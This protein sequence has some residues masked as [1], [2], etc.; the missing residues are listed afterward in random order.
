MELDVLTGARQLIAKHQPILQVEWL[1]SPKPQLRQTLEGFG[2]RVFEAGQN[3]LAIHP[4]D[5]SIEHLQ[6]K[7]GGA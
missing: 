6:P 4:T 7:P 2:Y 3:F 1:K 5:R